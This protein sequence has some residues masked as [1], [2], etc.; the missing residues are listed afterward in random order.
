MGMGRTAKSATFQ[1]WV[2]GLSLDDHH[3][4]RVTVS[5]T[6]KA[7]VHPRQCQDRREPAPNRRAP[8]AAERKVKGS[9]F[10]IIVPPA[11][12]EPAE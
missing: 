8:A 6:R 10:E 7:Y 1:D 12:Y 9:D 11:G 4:L 5:K 3:A 2:G